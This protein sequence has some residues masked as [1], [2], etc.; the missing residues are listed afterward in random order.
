MIERKRIPSVSGVSKD[1]IKYNLILPLKEKPFMPVAMCLYVTYRCNMR[2][3]MCGIW[4]LDS[5]QKSNEFSPAELENILSDPL[6]SKLEFIN[7][8]GGEPNLRDDLVDIVRILIKR[9][10]HL[11]TIT[12]NSNGLP[13][14]KTIEN[15]ESISEICKNNRIRFSVSLSLHQIG[16]GYDRIAGVKNAYAQ[17]K[18]S[19]DGLKPL[20][21]K[22]NMYL[23]ANCVITNSNVQNLYELLEW[24]RQEN[25]PVNFTLGEIRSRFNNLDFAD[26]ITIKNEHLDGLIDFFRR[27][28]QSKK[29]FK[30]HALRYAQLA[31]MLDSKKTRSLACH[32]AMGGI[33]LGSDSRIYYCKN[34]KSIGNCKDRPASAIYFDEENLRYRKDHLIKKRCLYCPPNTFNKIEAGKDML[35]LIKFLVLNK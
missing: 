5:S 22:N 30:H 8:N 11:K 19:F 34:S 13:P 29:T 14:E 6:F 4:K 1:F 15:A 2:C 32:Y 23:A 28:S 26:E 21:E 10:P 33:I 7:I 9:S 27:L 35:K 24:S 25:I 12:M 3:K 17:V 31:D 20:G 16:D 18:E